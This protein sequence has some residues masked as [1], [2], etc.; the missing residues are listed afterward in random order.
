MDDRSCL[1]PGC[2]IF[3]QAAILTPGEA[4]NVYRNPAVH[5]FASFTRDNDGCDKTAVKSLPFCAGSWEVSSR[6]TVAHFTGM[7]CRCRYP[8]HESGGGR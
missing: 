3:I 8:N 2:V 6:T 4:R 7:Y 1:T 5:A